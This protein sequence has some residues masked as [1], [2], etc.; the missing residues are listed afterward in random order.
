MRCVTQNKLVIA[1]FCLKLQRICWLLWYISL[2][3]P[4]SGNR[5]NENFSWTSLAE[6][7]STPS[8]STSV[9]VAKTWSISLTTTNKQLCV[10][11]EKWHLLLCSFTTNYYNKAVRFDPNPS[12]LTLISHWPRPASV[13]THYSW[14]SLARHCECGHFQHKVVWRLSLA[15]VLIKSHIEK[16]GLKSQLKNK[17]S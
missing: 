2:E 7:S 16:K 15:Q 5:D 8:N 14:M 10:E 17:L 12:L 9:S 4:H 11:K 6:L 13:N 1:L 3:K